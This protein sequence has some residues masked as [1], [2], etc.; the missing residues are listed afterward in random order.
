MPYGARTNT[1]ATDNGLV[2]TGDGIVVALALAAALSFAGAS[3]LQHQAASSTAVG[4]TGQVPGWIRL[5]ARPRWLAGLALDGAGY[6]LQVLALDRGA[7][8]LVQPLIASGLL[9]ALAFN[10]GQGGR[11]LRPVD[12]ATAAVC[13]A[14]L[15]GFVVLGAPTDPQR[16]DD[17]A[18]LGFCLV[19]ALVV[20]ALVV[21]ARTRRPAGRAAAMAIAAGVAY[22]LSAALTKQS[23][24]EWQYGTVH[25]LTTGYP[26]GLVVAGMSGMVIVQG[27]FRAGPL[28]A[29]LPAL[30][31]SEPT[32]AAVAGAALFGE[33]LRGGPPGWVAL[34]AALLS[35]A[36]VVRLARSP[37]AQ[38]ATH[39]A[40]NA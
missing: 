8:T 5:F 23:L 4:G 18:W 33:H 7:L 28:A 31:L 27:A 2:A 17:P 12:W 30:T 35:A 32:F 16:P 40:P 36:C 9:F 34:A 37:S 19:T 25:L 38:Q 26:Y 3:V 22:G 14:G 15:A 21:A 24:V 13:A 39:P 1:P 11:R 10:R 29:S 20:G 6:A